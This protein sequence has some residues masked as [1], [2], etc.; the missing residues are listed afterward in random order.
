MKASNPKVMIQAYRLLAAR[1][2]ELGPGLPLP[3][4][5]HRGRQRRGR[6]HQERHRHRQPARRRHRRHHPRLP[7]RGP[8]VRGARRLRPRPPLPAPPASRRAAAPA[9]AP[10]PGRTPAG[11]LP[12]ARDPYSTAAA[13]GYDPV[14]LR[15]R[16]PR[17]AVALGDDGA[18]R[19]GR[20]AGTRR[21]PL[22]GALARVPQAVERALALASAD[23]LIRAR[24]DALS[25]T[26][27]LRDDGRRTPCARPARGPGR[28]AADRRRPVPSLPLVACVAGGRPRR[29][30]GAVVEDAGACLPRTSATGHRRPRLRATR[31][32]GQTIAGARRPPRSWRSTPRARRPR[33]TTPTRRCQRRAAPSP[34]CW[35]PPPRRQRAGSRDIALSVTA[36]RPGPGPAHL[37]PAG[38]PPG[39]RRHGLPAAPRRL[40][41]RRRP[42][43]A[44]ARR[45]PPRRP[46]VRRHRRLGADHGRHRGWHRSGA[47][48]TPPGPAW[49]STS[50]RAPASACPRRSSSPAPPAAG[51]SSTCRRRPSASS[52]R[53]GTS[54][55]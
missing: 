45:R 23:G 48:T 54:R 38:R 32:P 11:A 35:P 5:R 46:A 27:A 16:S 24:P 20:P 33:A 39:R 25:V 1:L 36:R 40:A 26:G 34:A 41:G 28:R 51:R 21:P 47:W 10:T 4:R 17:G 44:A 52:A 37:P 9:R 7:H 42:G 12:D 15:T 29:R 13:C 18:G 53:R 50:C 3:P 30:I 2:D 6:A 43:R 22:A 19:A 49:P 31:R 8:G 55:A 14:R